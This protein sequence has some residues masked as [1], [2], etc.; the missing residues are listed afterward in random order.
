MSH[1]VHKDL[2]VILIGSFAFGY[3]AGRSFAVAYLAGEA[4]RKRVEQA[5]DSAADLVARRINWS[6]PVK[7]AA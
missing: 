4:A 6:E 7:H 2:P 3:V 1:H 5:A